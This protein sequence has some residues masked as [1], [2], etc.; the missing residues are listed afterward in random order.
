MVTVVEISGLVVCTVCAF[1]VTSTLVEVVA[2]DSL[3]AAR[4]VDREGSIFT[5]SSL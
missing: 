1:A 4:S 5:F 2:T 3:I